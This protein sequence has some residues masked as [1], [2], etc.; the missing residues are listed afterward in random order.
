[1]K[2]R[3]ALTRPVLGSTWKRVAGS[4]GRG[5]ESMIVF[6][7]GSTVPG[8]SRGEGTGLAEGEV[9]GGFD[10]SGISSVVRIANRSA[11]FI[12]AALGEDTAQ[13]ALPRMGALACALARSSL[14]F[15][16]YNGHAGTIHEHVQ[17]GNALLGNIRQNQ[18]PMDSAVRSM[19][20]A[21]TSKP[22]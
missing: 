6:P 16:S 12:D 20:L 4:V 21:V 17:L 7:F 14:G 22:A 2:N 5:P 19:A 13:F 18:M 15:N 9:L 8:G 3:P 1:M 11:F 10:G